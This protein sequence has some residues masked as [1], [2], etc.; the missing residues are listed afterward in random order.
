MLLN[1][2]TGAIEVTSS[3]DDELVEAIGSTVHSRQ[4]NRG[5]QPASMVGSSLDVTGLI[6]TYT[7]RPGVVQDLRS[8]ASSI[9]TAAQAC[10]ASASLTGPLAALYLSAA[11]C[12]DGAL[13]PGT[14][15]NGSPKGIRLL[16][17]L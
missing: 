9:R 3:S 16:R 1:I 10:N 8:A 14:A 13:A 7:S 6:I 12:R 15:N 2:V 5:C 11:F 4:K 17:K